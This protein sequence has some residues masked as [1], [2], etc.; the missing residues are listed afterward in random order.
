MERCARQ[1]RTRSSSNWKRGAWR[2][3]VGA[4]C[5][6]VSVCLSAMLRLSFA[7]RVSRRPFFTAFLETTRATR[8]EWSNL[9]GAVKN[10]HVTCVCVCIVRVC[11]RAGLVRALARHRLHA[12]LHSSLRYFMDA[13]SHRQS[14]HFMTNGLGRVRCLS[15]RHASLDLWFSPPPSAPVGLLALKST[16]PP[17][18]PRS[19][20]VCASVLHGAS[21]PFLPLVLHGIRSRCVLLVLCAPLS[22]KTP[23]TTAPA[24][25]HRVGGQAATRGTPLHTPS[26]RPS[27][28]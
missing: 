14:N 28:T 12:A 5:V 24:R 13:K 27:S 26:R 19:S 23:R 2:A 3:L 17:N 6:C 7:F 11:M 20:C 18:R 21:T 4:V 16:R 8:R 9:F 22:P 10:T 25:Q 15:T 1:R